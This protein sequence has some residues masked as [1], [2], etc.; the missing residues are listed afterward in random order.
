MR[1]RTFGRTGW[2]ISDIGYGMWGM[3]GPT[4]GWTGAD[5]EESMRSL[6]RAVERGCNFFDTAWVYGDGHSERLLGQLLAGHPNERLYAATK[7]PPKNR[8]W[9]ARPEFTLD[10][11]FPPDHIRKYAERSLENLHV[12]TID[13][14][15]FHVWSDKWV[16][17][18]RWQRA[19]DDLKSE[20]M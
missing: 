15:Q 19:L 13:L 18:E 9:P 8:Q 11:V 17:D 4:S 14:L 20:K 1:Y 10:E 7:I 5:D 6:E 12:S 3:G 2:K 16:N